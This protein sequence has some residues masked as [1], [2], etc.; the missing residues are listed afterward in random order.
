M[1]QFQSNIKRG[2]KMNAAVIYCSR[3]L[4]KTQIYLSKLK[5]K[6]LFELTD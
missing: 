4:Q 2:N 6:W 1:V 5:Q 3:Q